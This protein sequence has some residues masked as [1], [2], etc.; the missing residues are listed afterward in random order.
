MSAEVAGVGE[1]A[2]LLRR[3]KATEAMVFRMRATPLYSGA[4]GKGTVTATETLVPAGL[5]IRPLPST[6]GL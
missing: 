6:D 1:A 4:E 3:T 2:R 5:A